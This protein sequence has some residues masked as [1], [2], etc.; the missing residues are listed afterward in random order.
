MSQQLERLTAEYQR[1]HGRPPAGWE[2]LVRDGALR[3]VPHDP[4]GHP[5]VLN[6][7]QGTVTVAKD[8]PMWPLPVDNPR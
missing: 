3:G 1:R 6:P 4:A 8:S 5:F 2:D 7:S